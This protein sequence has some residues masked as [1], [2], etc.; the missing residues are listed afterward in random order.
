MLGGNLPGS[1]RVLTTA[2]VMETGMGHYDRAMAYGIV[3]FLLVGL[4]VG[5]LTWAQQSDGHRSCKLQEL[6]FTGMDIS[7]SGRPISLCAQAKSLASMVLTEP[8]KVHFSKHWQVSCHSRLAQ[9]HC[10]VRCSDGT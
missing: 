8:A 1:T 6:V 10:A 5:L 2:I 9:S 7:R 3:L 4:V